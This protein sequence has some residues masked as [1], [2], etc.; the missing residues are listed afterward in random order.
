M[1][2]DPFAPV[3]PDTPL[4]FDHLLHMLTNL[5]LCVAAVVVITSAVLIYWRLRSPETYEERFATPARLLRWR[6]WAHFSWQK[7]C[8]RCGLSAS[9]QVTRRDNEGHQITSTRWFHPK[10]LGTDVSRTTLRLTVRAR[11]GQTV[12]DLERAVPAIRDAAGAHSSRS[13]VVAPGTLRVE[14]VMREQLSTVGHAAP[15]TAVATTRV[16]LGRCENGKPWTLPLGGRHTLTVGCSGA[17]KG[18]VFWGIAGGLGPAVSAGVVRLVGIDLKYGIELSVGST[19]FTKIATTE[20]AAVETLAALE[21]LMN[22]R[23]NAMAGRTRK[24]SPTKASPLVVLLIDELAG[25]T[26]YMS[27]P[28][29]RKEAAASLSRIL[30]K[31]RALGIVVAAFLQDPRK[32]VLPMRG[33]FTQTIALRLRSRDEVAMVLGDGMADVAPAHRIS[34]ARPGTGYAV[35]EDGQVTKVRA[36]FWSDDQIISTAQ[37]Y[38]RPRT[39]G[40]KRND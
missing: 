16:T 4:R 38:G 30:T 10:L 36:D 14:L 7:L 19:L 8:K 32:E 2:P 21:K 3:D 33:L 11:M 9:E 6:L 13:V 17:G 34:P 5:A 40:G 26:A 31:G 15:P 12:E 37:Q 24:H 1:N 35:A 23:G 22:K 28:T 20:S 18:S 25:V 39:T 29:L 27:D